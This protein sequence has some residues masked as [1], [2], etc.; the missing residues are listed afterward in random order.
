[1]PEVWLAKK[2]KNH[3]RAESGTAGTSAFTFLPE[4][5]IYAAIVTSAA[6][7]CSGHALD[8][9]IQGYNGCLVM[10]FEE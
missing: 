8:T 3:H 2:N 6:H 5:S 9:A 1:V 4:I 7:S 10:F